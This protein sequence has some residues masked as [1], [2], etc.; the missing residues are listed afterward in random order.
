MTTNRCDIRFSIVG[1]DL[2]GTL[3]DTSG[4]LGAAVNHALALAGREPVPPAAVSGLIGGGAKLMLERALAMTGGTGG[5]DQDALFTQLLAYYEANIAVH[6]AL[7]PGAEAMLDA[8]AERGIKLAVVTN[9]RE[10]MARKLFD[11]LGLTS[12]FACIIGAGRYPLKPAPDALHVMVAELG[13]GAAAFVGDTTYDT[14]A[15]RAAGMPSVAVSFGFCDAAPGELG[16]DAVI[17]HFDEL[18]PAL[19]RL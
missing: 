8:L 13:G 2:D 15:A 17:G 16:A 14:H 7:Y 4:D 18:V 9:K 11:A 3:L 1:F 19:L 6:T 10:A 5:I 12:R